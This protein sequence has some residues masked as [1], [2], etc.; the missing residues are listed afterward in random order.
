MGDKWRFI[1]FNIGIFLMSTSAVLGRYILASSTVVVFWRCLIGAI[2]LIFITR[3]MRDSFRFNWIR[4]GRI[5]FISSVLMAV[6]WVTY[7]YSLDFSNVSIALLTLY[8]FPAM[9]ALMEPLWYRYRIPGK[10]LVLAG[11]VIIAVLIISPPLKEGSNIVLAIILGLFSAFCYSLRNIL[12]V[13]ITTKYP[14]STLMMYQLV[15]MT[16]LLLPFSLMIEVDYREF[17]WIAVLFLGILTTAAAH[18]LFLRGLS[19]YTASTA[20]LFATIVPVYAITWGYLFLRE[21]PRLNTLIGGVLIVGVV[22][23]K[24]LERK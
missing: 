14:G 12:L 22:F 23:V 17:Q 19:Y 15:F 21:I 8:T 24:A 6:H 13:S 4:H 2:C 10:D 20:S 7:F 18:T 1:E 5:L 3:M 9:T 16:L 11:V